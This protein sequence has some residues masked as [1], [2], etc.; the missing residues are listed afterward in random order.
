[1]AVA[2]FLTGCLNLKPAADHT[3]S[4][5]LTAV[6]HGNGSTNATGLPVGLAPVRLPPHTSSSWIAI[7]TGP[8]ELRYSETARWAEPL[9]RNVQ[10]VLGA[11][12]R[13]QAGLSAVF[14]N[15]WPANAVQRELRIQLDPI[16]LDATGTIVLGAQ[17]TIGSPQGSAI[18]STHTAR[19][20]HPGPR[21]AE[22]IAG[23]VAALSEA[24]AELSHLI[25][26]SLLF[27]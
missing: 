20:T 10:R 13:Q 25:A 19:V 14:L 7:R 8:N 9:D 12:L 17:W 24:L 26:E 11:N 3:R 27:P 22:D 15:T 2:L 4:F 6:D 18:S 21:P 1:M 5:L 23:A 16:D